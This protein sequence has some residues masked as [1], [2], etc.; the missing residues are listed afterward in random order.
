MVAY[1]EVWVTYQ[2]PKVVVEKQSN[3]SYFNH[4]HDFHVP[5]LWK[6]SLVVAKNPEAERKK[7]ARG[8]GATTGS[9]HTVGE[10][11]MPSRL[12]SFFQS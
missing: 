12:F 7:L 4:H 5:S 9:C 3:Q 10:I 1:F 2:F 6:G 8:R 11:H